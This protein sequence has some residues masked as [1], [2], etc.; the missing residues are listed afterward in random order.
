MVD[1]IR[2]F[3]VDKYYIT[4]PTDDS[5]FKLSILYFQQKKL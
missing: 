1:K 2:K 5:D 4:H 3:L